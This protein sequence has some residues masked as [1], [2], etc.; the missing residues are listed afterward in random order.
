M[1][2]DIHEGD[3]LWRCGE[4]ARGI[5]GNWKVKK[6]M[7]TAFSL[8]CDHLYICMLFDAGL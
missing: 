1:L 8:A 4:Y 7:I 2:R 3:M 6:Q 5:D